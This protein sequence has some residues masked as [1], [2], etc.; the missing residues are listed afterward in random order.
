MKMFKFAHSLSIAFGFMVACV[1][2]VCGIDKT[3]ETNYGLSSENRPATKVGNQI[4]KGLSSKTQKT[5]RQDSNYNSSIELSEFLQF[6]PTPFDEND[7]TII[8]KSNK[9]SAKIISLDLLNTPQ[10]KRTSKLNPIRAP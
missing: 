7:T 5:A 4:L 6:S 8:S 2:T 1:Q 3:F 10:F 9:K